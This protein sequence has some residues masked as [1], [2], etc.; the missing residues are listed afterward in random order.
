MSFSDPSPVSMRRTFRNSTTIQQ[1]NRIIE[2]HDQGKQSGRRSR[3][4]KLT[5]DLH[6]FHESDMSHFLPITNR[7]TTGSFLK[8][9]L[10]PCSTIIAVLSLTALSGVLFVAGLLDAVAADS[11]GGND[12]TKRKNVAQSSSSLKFIGRVLKP[13][14]SYA[15]GA[16]VR[17]APPIEFDRL[18]KELH[19]PR[20]AEFEET[21]TDHEGRFEIEANP[22]MINTIYELQL[23]AA[24]KHPLRLGAYLEGFGGAWLYSDEAAYGEQISIRLVEDHLIRGRIVNL[25]GRPL[26]K[27]TI[28]I[29]SVEG[30]QTE[31]LSPWFDAVQNAEG[32]RKQVP[33]IP[34]MIAPQLIGLPDKVESDENGRFVIHGA[35]KERIAELRFEAPTIASQHIC[36]ATRD[37]MLAILRMPRDSDRR[38]MPIVTA[39]FSW[40]VPDS[41]IIHGV[42]IDADSEQPLAEVGI[43]SIET[44]SISDKT[45]IRTT[46]DRQ[47]RFELDGLPKSTKT[48]LLVKPNDNQPYFYQIVDVPDLP[49][50][51]PV[52][53]KVQLRRGIWI[54]GRVTNTATS[55]PVV[56]ARIQYMPFES[57]PAVKR[58]PNFHMAMFIDPDRYQTDENGNYRIVGLPGPG[59]VAASGYYQEFVRGVGYDK[60]TCPK[61]KAL[62]D[63]AVLSGWRPPGPDFEHTLGEISPPVAEGNVLDL[64]LDPG[65]FVLIQAVDE[66]G[67]PLRDTEFTELDVRLF[68]K[69]HRKTFAPDGLIKTSRLK[70]GEMRVVVAY[71]A[72]RHLAKI[73]E[74]SPPYDGQTINTTLMRCARLKGRWVQDGKSVTKKQIELPHLRYIS[75]HDTIAPGDFLPT[76]LTDGDGRFEF[77]VLANSDSFLWSGKLNTPRHITIRP[78]QV[79]DLGEIDLDELHG[80]LHFSTDKKK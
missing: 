39:T 54:R 21:T 57:N 64:K 80:L 61:S 41:R 59:V 75:D 17:L 6:R 4:R 51:S 29:A 15:A 78:G 56:A 47:G 38:H 34:R 3:D 62:G 48:Y 23:P 50:M 44:P 52:P 71:Q 32:K 33:F 2:H 7:K 9:L 43:E 68:A 28:K 69:T 16:T 19:R 27:T 1:D 12:S 11:K 13:D 8:Q 31:D 25:E 70:S 40:P 55:Q 79:R 45:T 10:V 49:G 76:T 30:T 58:H 36:V 24:R 42:V 66:H 77:D 20:I 14:G 46:T 37:T 60:L 65:R 72:D 22:D 67:N 53:I 35:G 63:L 5:F 18:L 26:P 74:L 73:I